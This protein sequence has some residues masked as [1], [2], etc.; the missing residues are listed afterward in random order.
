MNDLILQR[1]DKARG[2]L[3]SCRT[4][5]EV[6]KVVDMSTAAKVY[7]QRQKLGR[8]SIDYAHGV[9]AD[10]ERLL[11]QF[12]KA[13]PKN[14]GAMGIGKSA[15]PR[16]HHTLKDSGLSKKES[17]KA[18]FVADLAD[19]K[20]E[21]FGQYAA[22]QVSLTELRRQEVREKASS[23]A[24]AIPKGKY[25]VIYADPPWKYGDSREGLDGTTGASAHYPSMSIAELCN[26]PI[27][28]LAAENAVLFMWT[29]SPLLFECAPVIKAWG[30]VYKASFVWDKIR[31]NMG[32]YNSVRH[33][34]LLVCTRGSCLPDVSK[35][36]DSVVSVERTAHS[37]KPKEFRE[38]IDD[39]YPHGNRIELFARTQAEGWEHWGNSI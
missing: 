30:F 20:P 1:V 24:R 35:L 2:L 14:T 19:K 6:K 11:G 10:A 22:N 37:E 8:E 36:Y 16:G 33:E 25:R 29:T 3:A 17:S 34:F 21:K 5:P 23:K 38:M 13:A 26:L 9:V 7:A 15:V 31:H 4:V 32:H 39:L 12:L 27:C 18:Q 28:D